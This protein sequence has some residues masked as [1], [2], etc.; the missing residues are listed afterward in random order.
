MTPIDD[1]M[2][3]AFADGEL[4]SD[5]RGLVEAALASDPALRGRLDRHQRLRARIAEHYAPIAE[6]S[7]PDRFTTLLANSATKKDNVLSLAEAR[8][9]RAQPG[10]K[11]FA[12]L[13]ATLVLGLFGGT[14]I[15]P[16]GESAIAL[17]EGAI[18]A[19][20]GLAKALDTQLASDPAATDTRIGVTFAARDGR[21]CRTFD[22]VVVTG[23][24]CRDG[25]GWR[26]EAMTRGSDPQSVEYRQASSSNPLVLAAAQELMAGEPFDA[27]AER[28]ARAAGW[29]NDSKRD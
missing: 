7:L 23:L 19:R 18:M 12:A 15:T 21:L 25:A 1:E 29:R 27:A 6:E 4:D 20:G 10:W 2:L 26:I 17:E 24:A 28:L 13:A 14:M 22:S 16:G 5:R 9:K 3:I 11:S 8:K